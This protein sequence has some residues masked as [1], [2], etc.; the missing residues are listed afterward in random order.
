[1]NPLLFS[2]LSCILSCLQHLN[3]MLLESNSIKKS[4]GAHST[5]WSTR[6]LTVSEPS[7]MPLIDHWCFSITDPGCSST[8]HYYWPHSQI[9]TNQGSNSCLGRESAQTCDNEHHWTIDLHFSSLKHGLANQG[10]GMAWEF[11]FHILFFLR[12]PC[13]LTSMQNSP[14]GETNGAYQ[15][16]ARGYVRKTTVSNAIYPED[17]GASQQ[18]N[19]RIL[20]GGMHNS[21]QLLQREW[22]TQHYYT[23]SVI[24]AR[25]RERKKK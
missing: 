25:L 15:A 16:A 20:R 4:V 18:I 3:Q 9:R 22:K 12:R 7:F 13:S 1:M 23:P 24:I 2:L 17:S 14:Y 8:H 21:M 19:N 5:A 10:L 11:S 6:F